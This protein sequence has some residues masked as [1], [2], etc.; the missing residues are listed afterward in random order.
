M[1]Y[2]IQL[3]STQLTLADPQLHDEASNSSKP[4][5]DLN[6]DTNNQIQKM[7]TDVHSINEQLQIMNKNFN[8][9]FDTMD[10]NLKNCA[11]Q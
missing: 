5:A 10:E 1:N 2:L 3:M 6:Q 8:K 7:N 4:A 9:R 11:K